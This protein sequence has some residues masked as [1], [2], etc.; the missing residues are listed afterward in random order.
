MSAI[1]LAILKS[2]APLVLG[3]IVTSVV[4]AMMAAFGSKLPPLAQIAVS[5]AA[6]AVTAATSG[7]VSGLTQA[8]TTITEGAVAGVAGSKARDIVVGKPRAT[9]EMYAGGNE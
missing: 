8:A 5:A 6:G 9:A 3:P 7:D 2:V 1:L 4:K